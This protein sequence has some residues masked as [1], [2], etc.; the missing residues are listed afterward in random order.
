MALYFII[1]ER[2]VVA[3]APPVENHCF[4]Q[5]HEHLATRSCCAAAR[6]SISLQLPCEAGRDEVA[7]RRFAKKRLAAGVCL[8]AHPARSMLLDSSDAVVNDLS[9]S[10]SSSGPGEDD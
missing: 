8:Y 3:D 4:Q 5:K 6:E 2:N 1:R 7:S 10:A 9:R